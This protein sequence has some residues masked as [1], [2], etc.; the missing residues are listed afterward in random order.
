MDETEIYFSTLS[1][2]LVTHLR[3]FV[4]DLCSI[5][6]FGNTLPASACG[7]ETGVFLVGWLQLLD[8]TQTSAST[9]HQLLCQRF[10]M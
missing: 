5:S 7:K 6:G 8:F 3:I 10:H 1:R 4:G 2:P 9:L